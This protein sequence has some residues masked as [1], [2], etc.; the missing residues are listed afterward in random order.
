MKLVMNKTLINMNISTIKCKDW[1]RIP[2]C[3]CTFRW[4]VCKACSYY[5]NGNDNPDKHRAIEPKTKI[6]V[7]DSWRLGI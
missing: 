5:M 6:I 7:C 4:V 2:D 3:S 1:W